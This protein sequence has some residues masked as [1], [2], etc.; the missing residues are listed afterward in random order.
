MADS[1][2]CI[3]EQIK[4]AETAARENM[5]AASVSALR[6]EKIRLRSSLTEEIRKTKGDRITKQ[7]IAHDAWK[8]AQDILIYASCGAE[9]STY[10]AIDRALLEGKRVFCPKVEGKKMEFYRI[11]SPGDLK[12]GFRGILE[13]DGKT[14]FFE[15]PGREGQRAARTDLQKHS[16]TA[17]GNDQRTYGHALLIAP[18]TVFDRDGHRIGYG[19]GY[20]DRYLGQFSESGRPYC[21]GLCFLCQLTERI[22]PERHDIAMNQVIYA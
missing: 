22:V 19:G 6:K 8:N 17:K 4:P 13:P 11:F 15:I 10:D 18:G 16:S 7:L 14:A 9:V 1:R 5:N 3:E 21:I 20:Y 2:I 12:P